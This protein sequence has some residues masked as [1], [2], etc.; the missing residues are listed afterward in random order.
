MTC[1]YKEYEVKIR[2]ELTFCG[3]NKNFVGGVYCRE[4][5]P[6]GRGMSKPLAGGGTH[7]SSGFE[8]LSDSKLSVELMKNGPCRYETWVYML[9]RCLCQQFLFSDS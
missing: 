6:V 2:M 1:V 8:R 4:F 7:S 9:R 3:G 5:F